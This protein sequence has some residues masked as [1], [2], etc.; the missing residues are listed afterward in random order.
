MAGSRR[1]KQIHEIS[2]DV[3][4]KVI[5]HLESGG[6]KKAACEMLGVSSNPTMERMIEEWQDRQTQVAE[7]KKKKRGTLI[8]GVELANVIEQYLSGDSFEEIADRNYRSV[9]MIKSVLERYGALLRINDIVDPLHPPMVPDD[10]MA[11]EFEVGELVWVP[12]YQCIG[13]VKKTLTNPVGAYRVWLLG[14]GKQQNV[15][16]M[17]YE[18]A[19]VKHLQ[20]LGVDVKALGF[21]YSREEVITLVNEAV[22]AALK[23]DKEKG[24]RGE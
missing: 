11:E 19:S 2:D 15:H 21:K 24:R 1:K 13:E 5:E 6:T 23:L 17:N 8:Q 18:L 12:G 14:E 9:A 4:K 22:K 7:M 20:E 16:Y 10:A 3:F